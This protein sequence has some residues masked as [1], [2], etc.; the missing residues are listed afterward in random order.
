MKSVIAAAVLFV[1]VIGLC[2]FLSAET[3]RRIDDL[4]SLTEKL[5]T[6]ADLLTEDEK[7]VSAQAEA[8]AEYWADAVRYFSYV[9]GYAVLNR[10]DEAVWDLYA[11]VRAKD[12]AAAVIARYQMLDALRRMRELE[13]ISLSSVF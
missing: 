4:S 5:P 7:A 9:C 8:I 3:C 12:Y 13:G 2:L 11:A 10:A 6:T 1:C